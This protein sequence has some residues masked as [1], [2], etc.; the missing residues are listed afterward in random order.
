MFLDY[1]IFGVNEL[2]SLN[3]LLDRKAGGSSEFQSIV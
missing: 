1:Q 2:F 3:S